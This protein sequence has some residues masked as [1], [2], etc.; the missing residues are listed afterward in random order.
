MRK[1][2]S[3]ATDP[4]RSLKHIFNNLLGRWKET[5]LTMFSE[6][7]SRLNDGAYLFGFT[8]PSLDVAGAS[9]S[10]FPA[11]AVDLRSLSRQIGVNVR[12]VIGL[13]YLHLCRVELDFKNQRITLTRTDAAKSGAPE[14]PAAT[15]AAPE[16]G[17]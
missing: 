12:G 11:T 14:A 10:N 8:M 3:A 1:C 17:S 15:P 5:G 9:F 6:D 2:C 13:S 4:S 16:P 7:V